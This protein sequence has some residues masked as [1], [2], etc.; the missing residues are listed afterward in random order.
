MKSVQ[1]Y[2]VIDCRVSDPIQLKG[3]SLDDQEVI[4]RL[5]AEKL[6]VTVAKVFKKPHSATTTE[7]DDFQE[8]IDYIEKDNRPI[9]YYIV[10]SLD[11]LTRGGYTEYLR[12]KN[13]LEKLKIEI[14]DAQGVIQPKKNTL[15]HLGGFKYKWSE[16][17]P[18]EAG[19]MLETYKGKAE[20]RDILTRMIGAEI[21]LVQEGY[22][23]RRAPDGL[24]NKEV[25]VDGKDKVIREA[26]AGRAHYF[27]RMFELLADGMD[28]LEVCNRLNALSFRTR[29]YNRWD[30]HDKEHPKIVGQTSGKPL[31]VKQLQR[32]ILQ[33]EYAGISYEKWNRHHPVKMEQFDGIVSID[34]FNKANRGKIYIILNSDQSIA[35]R[36][37]YSPWGKM[38]RLRDNPKYPWKCIPC[39]FCG[40][41]MLASIS[42][43]KYPAYHCGGWT[44]KG[45][46]RTHEYFRI[47]Q[48]EFEK[49]VC[50]YL[51][52]LKFDDG[53]LAGLELHI[54]DKYREREKEILV[55]SSAI[56]RTVSDL[57]SELAKKLD[58]FG[59]AK[60]PVTRHMIE[61][62][63]TD[64]DTQ[65]K[66]AE[67]ERG[68]IE[69]NEK[70]I[71]A[72]RQYAGY[73]MEHPAEILTKSEDLH[74]RRA[75]LSLFFEEVPTYNEILNGTPKLTSL[76][77]L[78]EEFKVNKSQLV[79]PRGVEPRFSP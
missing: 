32:Y 50:S 37:N 4:G 22:A 46:K 8:V 61:M 30:R 76:F 54:I 23:V 19:E 15:E 36:H 58:T 10:K 71:R 7:R 34:T 70:S 29:I 72:F 1:E 17:S 48:D 53:F 28:Y 11:R 2:C 40:S 55:D 12:L 52:S 56:S 69:I 41:E 73:I 21:V 9:K 42:K 59:F 63:I 66:Q 3:G 74:S 60:S 26:D 35:I 5:V 25:I 47:P 6:G 77:K 49:N 79:T 65:I 68:K 57:K 18:S 45:S 31:T 78:S 75:L 24:K 67:G 20:A 38:K 16:Y 14:V 62:Q 27:Q 39:P 33:T 13:E 44:G 64:L 51:D 43:G